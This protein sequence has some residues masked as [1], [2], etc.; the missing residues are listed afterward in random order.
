MESMTFN[1]EKLDALIIRHKEAVQ[2]NEDAF[3]FEGHK[4]LTNY[5]KYLIQYL[6]ME[7]ARKKN[8]KIT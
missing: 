5:A 1:R 6:Q 3:N 4:L 2:N 8:T 7:L